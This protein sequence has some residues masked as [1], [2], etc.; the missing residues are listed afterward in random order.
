MKN[1]LLICSLFISLT[2]FAQLPSNTGPKSGTVSGKVI[3]QQTNEALPYVSIVIKDTNNKTI[4]GTITSEEG[5]FSIHKLPEGET[6][7]E[8]QFMGYKTVHKK[9]TLSRSN[10]R[11]DLGT[12]ALVEEATSLNEVEIIAETS[13]VTQKIDRKVINVGKDLTSA[14]ATASELL[15]NVQSVSVD[16]QTGSL[17]LRGN[18]NVRVLVDGK[19]TNISTEQL[20]KQIP[21]TSIKS[22]E[23]ITN[24]SAKYSPEGM[25]GII[26]I[27]L[28]KNANLGFNGSINSGITFGKNT[29]YNTSVNMNLKKGKLN[30]FVNYGFNKGKNSNNGG[31]SRFDNNSTQDFVGLNDNESHLIKAGV[32][33]Y[34]NDKNTLSVF[35]T[36]NLYDGDANSN[37]TVVYNNNDF[38]NI[39]QENIAINKNRS[40]TYN[41]NYKTEF[42]KEDHNLEFEV[43]YNKNN[44]DEN[45]IFNTSIGNPA[46]LSSYNDIVDND[47][48]STTIN[49]DYTNPI[50]EKGKLELGV[51]TRI[52]KTDNNYVSTSFDNSDYQYDRN[53]NS[54]YANYSHKFN[55]LTMQVGARLENYKVDAIQNGTKIYEDDY[56]TLYPSAFLTYNP[57]EKNQFQLSY[58]RRVDRPNLGQVNPIREWSTPTITSFGNPEL[59]PQ[60]TN[61]FEVNYT[62]QLKNGSVTVGTFYRDINNNI[63]RFFFEDPTD[64]NKTILTFANADGNSSYGVELSSNYKI[65][66]WWRTNI[67]FD[68]YSVKDQ[69]VIG[70]ENIEVTSTTWNTRMSNNFSASKNLKFQLFGMYRGNVQT[71]QWD[72]KPMWK[73]DFGASLN[74]LKGKGTVTARVSDIFESMSF[75]FDS[76]KPYPSTGEFFWESQN[77]YIGF[78]Y[79]FGGGKNKTRNR[80]R[81]DNNEVNGGG[82]F[83]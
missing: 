69:G 59:D 78:N 58:S 57:S 11:V 34:I 79:R 32:D 71:I 25:S 24:P 63:S 80:K 33:Y 9:V 83:F 56:T 67:S 4:N 6:T 60:F 75:N 73:I 53:I 68:L 16:S 30:Y 38:D 1:I 77:A 29:R 66:S 14:G 35:T 51:E 7:I 50:S 46:V 22:V 20:L 54:L 12:I 26:N 40:Q 64:P 13:T 37:S 27:V 49:I 28:H 43:N 76:E 41:L 82:G 8:I 74:V 55:K 31:V 3:D 48:T 42:D 36:Q 72:I 15:N 2:A 81:R 21:S 65:N 23:L 61:S 62:K 5:L 52:R 44:G 45:S 17:S 18:D 10:F 47:R 39:L 70:T 19:P